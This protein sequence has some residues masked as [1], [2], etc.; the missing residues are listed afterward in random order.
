MSVIPFAG[1]RPDDDP[2]I[3]GV[4]TDCTKLIPAL[5]GYKA[6]PGRVNIGYPALSAACQGSM[7]SVKLD[8]TYR[9]FAAT[10]AKIYEGVGSAWTDRTRTVGGDYTIGPDLS[11]SG[12]QFGDT[13]IVT[14]KSDAMQFSTSG[15]F[16]NIPT[17]PVARLAETTNGFV[18]VADTNDGT[19]GTTYGDQSDRWWCSSYLDATSAT[20]WTPNVA[21]QCTT[22]RLVDIPGPIR[23]L[24]RLGSNIVAYKD[25]GLFLGTYT[26][27]PAVFSWQVIPGDFGSGSQQSVITAGAQHYFVGY[28]DIYVFDGSRPVAIG[29]GIKRWFF[30]NLNKSYRYKIKGLHDRL[31]SCVWFFYPDNTSS[32]G[33]CNA[34]IVFN[35]TT[36]KWGRSDQSVEAVVELLTGQVTY[37][38]LGVL[39]STY[40]SIPPISYDSPFFTASAPVIALFGTDH[41]A[42]S[43]TGTGEDSSLTTGDYGDDDQYSTLT[44]ARLRF[45][46]KPTTATG[47]NYYKSI[48]GDSLTTGNAS[49][50]VDGKFDFL[51]SSRWHR[52]KFDFT[53]DMVTDALWMD[54]KPDGTR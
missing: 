1:L 17:S 45:V 21:T 40:D 4:I 35:Y 15:A 27:A 7:L 28:E 26:G 48:S 34:S 13:T 43:L 38:S 18:I 11:W 39:F 41:I 2:T 49:T 46:T 24:K 53:G 32:D 12:V 29:D 10:G 25:K 23:A 5:N 30:S 20:A 31:N 8:G 50:M 37:E 14:N 3:Q 33:T 44:K 9:W 54:I 36:Q 52:I 19:A 47:T 22:G 6:S 16:A 42:Y 51:W